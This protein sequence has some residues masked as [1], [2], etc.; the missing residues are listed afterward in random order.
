MLCVLG[1]IEF[2]RLSWKSH[3]VKRAVNY[4]QHGRIKGKPLLEPVF[5]ELVEI[6]VEL[7]WHK[8]FADPATSIAQIEA[9]LAEKL[10]LP[11]VMGGRFVG[12][13]VIKETTETPVFYLNNSL[14]MAS[15]ITLQLLEYAG[16][17][18]D[19]AFGP[20]SSLAIAKPGVMPLAA[21]SGATG[22]VLRN[23]LGKVAGVAGLAGL[24]GASPQQLASQALSL[25]A[26]VRGA[27]GAAQSAM[28]WMNQLTGNPLAA[29]GELPGVLGK[30]GQALPAASG[31][32]A[33][34][35][36]LSP[37]LADGAALLQAASTLQQGARGALASLRGAT[38]GNLL[39][40]LG[41]ATGALS[42]ASG[43]LDVLEKPLQG[44]LIA[45]VMRFGV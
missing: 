22:D 13:F 3:T 45:K 44:M 28:G 26:Q 38:S 10:P 14:L 34:M 5:D 7:A 23:G 25:G 17:L 24:A 12:V 11:L 16:P 27:L 20:P 8:M 36:Q 2:H 41:Q 19:E 32:Q 39:T 37:A 43:A 1:K 33:V 6:S 30:V 18:P 21:L 31:L 35:T 4:A 29:L 42:N 15:G 40:Q 9:A